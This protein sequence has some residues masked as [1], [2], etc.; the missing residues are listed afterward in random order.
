MAPSSRASPLVGIFVGGRGRRMGGVDK[1]NLTLAGGETLVARLLRAIRGA[2][3]EAPVVLVGAAAAYTELGLLALVDE[4]AGI[5]PL[6]GLAALLRQAQREGHGAALALACDMP[7]LGPGLLQRL[8]HEAPEAE[9]LAARDGGRWQT[10]AA[11]YA[12]SSLVAVEASIAAGE[13]AL[14]KVVARLEGAV[15]LEITE[16]ER[17]ELGDWDTPEDRQTSQ[18]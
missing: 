8:A 2:L 11:R 13:H 1:G 16:A 6:G 9:F 17:T 18:R 15:A 3:P 4:P 7:H 14:Q 5:G 10:L 12:A